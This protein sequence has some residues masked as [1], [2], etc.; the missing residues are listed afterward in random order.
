MRGVLVFLRFVFYFL[1]KKLLVHPHI[2]TSVWRLC[3]SGDV[4][5]AVWWL[6]QVIHSLPECA[7][8]SSSTCCGVCMLIM[9]GLPLMIDFFLL[10][11]SFLS[12][13]VQVYNCPLCLLFFNFSPYSLNFLFY[14]YSFYRSFVFFSIL[15]FNYNLSYVLFFISIF[16][17]LISYFVFIP[18]IVSVLLNLSLFLVDISEFILFILILVIF[19]FIWV[20]FIYNL[21]LQF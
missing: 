19:S 1:I 21:V 7:T 3:H 16:I 14:P 17:H 13:T 8:V 20:L 5:N 12:S 11:L 15:S 18:F 10:F 4:C 2:P 6:N 9:V